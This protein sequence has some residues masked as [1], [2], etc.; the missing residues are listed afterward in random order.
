MPLT[1]PLKKKGEDSEALAHYKRASQMCSDYCFPFHK[2]TIPVLQRAQ[3]QR[4]LSP[5]LSGKSAFRQT[6]AK[7]V[8]E[9]KK[10]FRLDP[11]FFLVHRS[12]GL[13]SARVKK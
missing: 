5:I 2:E 10:S 1:H 4:L 8:D 7:A 11:Q 13:V 3:P 6:T 9:L 12:L